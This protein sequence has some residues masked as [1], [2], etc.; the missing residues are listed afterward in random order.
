MNRF[1]FRL[2]ALGSLVCLFAL[3]VPA[4]DFQRTYNLGNDGSINIRNIS[5]DVK[6]TGYDGQAVVV[7]AFKEG[8]NLDRVTIEDQSSGNG[9]DVRARYP[10]HC[11]DCNV[12][13]RFDVKVPRNI[14]YRFNSISSISGEV[15]ATGITGELNAKSIS[16]EVTVNNVNGKV[17]VSSVS[18]SVHV[19]K[20]EGTVNAKSTSGNVEV[21]ILSLEGGAGNMEFGSVSG[22]VRVRMPG[23]LDANVTLST[24]SGDL[25]TDFPLTIEESKWG[26]GRKA[27]GRVGNGSR[28]LRM[29]SVSGDISLLSR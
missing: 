23:N 11:D 9:I 7:M 14:A 3:T 24:M 25:K 12:S 27:N 8:R 1:F 29:S 19:G 18:G 13:V 4:Q 22:N 6:V 21:E 5:G 26:T 20:V 16:G 15:E 10:E 28:T 17:S 2:T